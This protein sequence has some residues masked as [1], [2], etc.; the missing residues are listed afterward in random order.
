MKHT[1]SF[2]AALKA[3]DLGVQITT[4]IVM[5]VA[6]F[7]WKWGLFALFLMAGVQYCSAVLWQL[8]GKELPVTRNRQL[9]QRVFLSAGTYLLCCGALA[10]LRIQLPLVHSFLGYLAV[11]ILVAGPVLGSWYFFTTATEISFYQKLSYRNAFR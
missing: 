2:A 8:A 5:I 6:M 4:I 10:L 7:Q 3:I 9:L 1:Y 11:A